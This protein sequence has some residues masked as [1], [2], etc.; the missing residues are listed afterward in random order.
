MTPNGR[1]ALIA[2]GDVVALLVFTI[3]GLVNHEDGVTAAATL[4]VM[5]PIIAI[6]ALAA[7]VFGTYS[8]PAISTLLPAWAISVPSGILIRKALFGTPSSWGSTG[9]FIGV[10]LAFTLLFLLAWRLLARFLHLGR[11]VG[12]SA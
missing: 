5:L 4:K 10:A 11:A 12:E 3:I 1:R 8:R 7:L 2:S 9:V 6:G